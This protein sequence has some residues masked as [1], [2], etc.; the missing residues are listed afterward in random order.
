MELLYL[1]GLPPKVSKGAL[2]RLLTEDGNLKRHQIGRIMVK[3][4]QATIEV[5][6]GKAARLVT[7]LDGNLVG[8]RQIRAWQA[9]R[10][11][12]SDYFDRLSRWLNL[13]AKAEA[14]QYQMRLAAQGESGSNE[15]SLR[16]MVMRR[17]ALGMGGIFLIQFGQRDQQ[18][19]LPWT[20]LTTGSPVIVTEEGNANW[21]QRGIVSRLYRNRIEIALHQPLDGEG[22]KPSY[23]IDLAN[24]EVSRE[25]MEQALTRAA[26][27]K[28]DRLADLR[29]VLLGNEPAR[30][31]RSLIPSLDGHTDRLNRSQIEAIEHALSAQDVAIIHGPPGTGKTT[32]LIGLMSAAVANGNKILACAPS[33]LAVDN[34]VEKLMVRGI[35]VV[36][37]GHPV[38]VT[39]AAQSV[40][41]DA[42]VEASPNYKLA[43]KLHK[44][45][46]ELHRQAG[47]W[48]RAK[49][50]KGAKQALREEARA[51]QAEA[52]E[53]EARAIEEILNRADVI[54][55]TLTGVDSRI[56]GQRFF[57]LCVIDE[58]G[59]ST[60]PATWIPLSRCERVVLAGDHLQLPPT[61]ISQQAM[62]EGYG[63]SLLEK[64]MQRD[65]NQVS[66]RLD[67]QYRMHR[68]IMGYS[69]QVFYDNSLIA[70][71]SVAEH[72]LS[73][74]PDVTA[75]TETTQPLDMID[76]AGAS[77]DEER[78]EKESS[79]RNPKEAR[80]V[81]SQ[82]QTL[83]DHGVSPFEMAVITPY[84][85]QVTFIRELVKE[86][87]GETGD[88]IE[89][90]SVDGFQG[91]EKEA[92]I[93][94]LV[95][96]NANGEIGFLA[97]SRRMNVALT[98]ARRRLVVI[99][100]SAT[101][102]ADPF[103]ADMVD[104]F[105]AQGAYRTVWDLGVMYE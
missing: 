26:A 76:T 38:R 68:Q 91:R 105:E 72:L 20:R 51:M 11:G 64:L 80:L 27:A 25:R 75:E 36:R 85:A 14:E 32:T 99:G 3:G 67:R 62:R 78:P 93:I 71:G 65:G 82:I 61:I 100:D 77:F 63:V 23:R 6:D 60:E 74:L 22:A 29:E 90:N 30:F 43:R 44:D 39:D 79:R 95:R 97:E 10:R 33:N 1:D 84:S 18:T 7:L 40:T 2:M 9:R 12:D 19:D 70:D 87:L 16:R 13:E 34:L 96:S 53:L 101:V 47:K 98:R 8:T 45:A 54:L 15:Y 83:L 89:V 102:T 104:Y 52:R 94:S 88:K 46:A 21:N 48:R 73:E 24:D 81:L 31:E 5:A 35:S 66:R 50:E 42:L 28:S 57:D 41:L 4:H 37:L 92:I 58:A 49:P 17:E 59:Q 103:F 56:L 69:S 86:A 55:S